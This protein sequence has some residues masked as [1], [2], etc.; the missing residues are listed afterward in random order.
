MEPYEPT[1]Q[2]WQEY[3]QMLADE[4]ICDCGAD[5]EPIEPMCNDCFNHELARWLNA[6]A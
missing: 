1:A 6:D 2:D 5:K 4:H 3:E